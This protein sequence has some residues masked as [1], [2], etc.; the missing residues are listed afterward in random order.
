MDLH[1][2]ESQICDELSGAEDYIKKA[3]EIKPMN[4]KWGDTFVKMSSAELEHAEDLK[5]ML[6]EY[7]KSLTEKMEDGRSKTRFMNWYSEVVEHYI[8]CVAN[9]KVLHSMY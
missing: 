5:G 6:D 2:F 4:A 7:Y 1:Y 9:V 8:S 3:L